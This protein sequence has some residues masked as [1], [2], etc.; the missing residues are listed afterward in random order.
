MTVKYL[1]IEQLMKVKN[2]LC[3]MCLTKATLSAIF[4]EPV[5]DKTRKK[6]KEIY[7][8]FLCSKECVD[9]FLKKYS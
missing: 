6:K 4:I 2:I 5:A 9:A 3:E 8:R 7:R 1:P